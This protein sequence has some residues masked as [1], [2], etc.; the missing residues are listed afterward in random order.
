MESMKTSDAY[1][2]VCDEHERLSAEILALLK[3]VPA[4]MGIAIL[5]YLNDQLSARE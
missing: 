1:K 3:G 4:F 2:F 5:K